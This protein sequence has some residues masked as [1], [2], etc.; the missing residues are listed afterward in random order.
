[1]KGERERVREGG[2]TNMLIDTVL[3]IYI[4]YN[5]LGTQGLELLK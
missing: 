2:G 5:K 4:I 3:F 1:M